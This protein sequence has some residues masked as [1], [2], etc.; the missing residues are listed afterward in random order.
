M[1]FRGARPVGPGQAR[2]HDIALRGG[3]LDLSGLEPEDDLA[4]DDLPR[5]TASSTTGTPGGL[6]LPPPSNRFSVDG[7]PSG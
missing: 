7:G 6:G 2:F 5:T 4:D 1:A 3:E